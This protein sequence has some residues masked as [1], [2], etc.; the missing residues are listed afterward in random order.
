MRI[1]NPDSTFPFPF[2]DPVPAFSVLQLPN[3]IHCVGSTWLYD[4]VYSLGNIFPLA[5][6]YYH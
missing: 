5:K 3:Y 4:A 2:P 1:V 6:T